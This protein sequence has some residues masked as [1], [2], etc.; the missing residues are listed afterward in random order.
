MEGELAASV[1]AVVGNVEAGHA[2]SRGRS[3]GGDKGH[4][5][6]CVGTKSP[7]FGVPLSS[8]FLAS[9]ASCSETPAPLSAEAS[10]VLATSLG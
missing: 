5:K 9:R 1:R 3:L 10:T 8:H 6:D 7:L 2:L 4:T